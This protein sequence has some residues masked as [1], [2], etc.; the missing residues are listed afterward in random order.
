MTGGGGTM[1][2]VAV[3]VFPGYGHVNPTLELT[4]TL[5]A[6]GHRVTYVLDEH[7]ADQA[8]ATG[9]RVV[10]YPTQRARLG[11][12]AVT[13]EDIGSLGLSFLRECMDVVLPRTLEAFA[14]DV[15]DLILYDLESF[16]TARNAALAWNRP[17]VQMY[18]YAATNETYSLALEVFDGAGANIGRCIELVSEYLEAK[19]ES[20]DALMPFLTNYDDRNL[21]L[22]PRWFQ[23][24]G[25]TFDDRYAFVGHSLAQEVP[26]SGTWT[27]PAEAER[28]VLITLGTEVNDHPEFFRMCDTAFADGGWH[29]VLALGRESLPGD[30]PA[31]G[32]VELHEWIPF[33]TVVPN[34][35]AV[36]CHAGMSTMLLALYFDKPLVIV[37][38][39][40]EEKVS[41]RMV[42]QLGIGRTLLPEDVTAD[43]LRAAVEQVT[44]D[45]EIRRRVSRMRM[46][47][48]AEGGPSRAALLVDDWLNAPPAEDAPVWA[49]HAGRV[50]TEIS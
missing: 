9:A 48:L 42:E 12:G 32:H 39:S 4:R 43:S 47:L 8:A 7:L 40:P 45:P 2:H 15:P 20:P 30:P 29:T 34:V 22:M 24:H 41:G 37:P 31:G 21:V 25:E 36:V 27:P 11:S 33:H 19:G 13:G 6:L 38:Y 14:D 46:H 44:T 10:S 1:K 3:F 28:S 50:A 35:D 5:L 17:T 26:G 23:P 18:A 16:F 49:P